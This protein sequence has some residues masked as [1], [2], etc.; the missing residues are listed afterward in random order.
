MLNYAELPLRMFARQ[1]YG[2]I[3]GVPMEHLARLILSFAWWICRVGL[4]SSVACCSMGHF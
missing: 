1:N 4:S 2:S 3:S